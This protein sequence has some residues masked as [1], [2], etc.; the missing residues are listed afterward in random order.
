[1]FYFHLHEENRTHVTEFLHI[2]KQTNKQTYL[3]LQPSC[4][5]LALFF[6]NGVSLPL[7]SLSLY[8]CSAPHPLPPSWNPHLISLP[9]SL[10]HSTS[11]SQLAPSHQHSG[12]SSAVPST[13]NQLNNPLQGLR[14]VGTLQWGLPR[15]HSGKEYAGLTPGSGR[16]SSGEGNDHPL[17]DS[18]LENSMDRGAWKATVHGV[19]K[20][21]SEHTQ[22][23]MIK[24]PIVLKKSSISF[25]KHSLPLVPMTPILL[26]FLLITPAPLPEP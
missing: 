5:Q 17:Q 22:M 23:R 26:V 10:L 12:R 11:P 1:M 24:S 21:W 25:W 15:W 2:L 20:S 16:R 14:P 7:E 13:T 3:H 4:P 18:C 9:F 8:L 19:T 6:K